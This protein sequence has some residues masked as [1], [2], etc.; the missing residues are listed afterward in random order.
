MIQL[1]HVSKT[2][3]TADGPILAV[4]DASL[5]IEPGE[6]FGIIGFSGAGKSTLLRTINLLEQPDEGSRI[7][8]DGQD[9]VT[10]TKPALNRARQSIGMVFQHFNLLHNRTVAEN[11]S[12]PLEIAGKRKRERQARIAECLDIVGLSAK[13]NAYPTQLSG[14]QKQRVGIARALANQPKVLLCDEPT[15]AVDPQTTGTLLKFLQQIN[16]TLGI[17]IV[18]V[19]HEMNVVNAICHRVAVMEH[20]R[21]VEEF[22]LGDHT[23]VPQSNIA[24]FLLPAR[25]QAPALLSATG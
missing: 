17:T 2:F 23:F 5:H 21:V 14:G 3:V 12:L 16:R 19:T 8:V 25:A 15:S 13:A 11:V 18:I 6:I 20:G 22:A 24:K 7:V 10:L 9:L 1:D 4:V